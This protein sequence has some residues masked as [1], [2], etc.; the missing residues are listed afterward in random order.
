M[1]YKNCLMSSKTSKGLVLEKATGIKN[2]FLN[3]WKKEFHTDVRKKIASISFMRNLIEYTRGPTDPDFERLTSLLHWK[4]DS[5]QITVSDLDDIYNNLFAGNGTSDD[6]QKIVVEL[7]EQ[8]ATSCLDAP[9]GI[10]LENKVVLAIATRIAVEKF[11]VTRINDPNF[12][13]SIKANQTA[14]LLKKFQSLFPEEHASI[15]VLQR[16]VLMTPENIHLN[17]FMYEPIIDMSDEHLRKLYRDVQVL[18]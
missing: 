3:A 6:D 15:S 1:G 17:S 14:E 7:I 13:A 11:M 16:V 5:A 10:N 8:E 9:E 12:V 18:K 4:S 2:I